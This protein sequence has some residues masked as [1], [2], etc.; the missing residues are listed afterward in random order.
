MLETN[1]I[2]CGDCLE[3]M[4]E[5]PDE[6]IDFILT[7]PPFNVS[8]KYNSYNDHMSDEDYSNYLLK[9]FVELFRVMKDGTYGI[10]FT[11]DKNLYWVHKAVNES[12]L[13]YHHFLKWH[14]P[15]CHRALPGTV[16]FGT[17]ELAFVVSKN[18]PNISKIKRKIMYS[19]TLTY[20]NCTPPASYEKDKVFHPAERPVG[21]YN[22]QVRLLYLVLKLIV[23][24]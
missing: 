7:D 20:I 12:G 18:K 3:L 9:R 10:I 23:N 16:L 24:L 5:L 14:K 1:K 13:N 11:G 22:V 19:D 8:L 6:S 21:L 17:T 2:Y 4:K 15:N